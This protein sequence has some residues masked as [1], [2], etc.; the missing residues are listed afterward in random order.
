MV[1]A[2]GSGAA[3]AMAVRNGSGASVVAAGGFTGTESP[4]PCSAA[5]FVA[6]LSLGNAEAVRTAALPVQIDLSAPSTTDT[7]APPNAAPIGIIP[8]AKN[9]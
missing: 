7:T 8:H 9:R 6:R 5:G 4:I 1:D 2:V 3:G